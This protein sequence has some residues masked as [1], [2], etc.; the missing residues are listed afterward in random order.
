MKVEVFCTS[1][2]ASHPAAV[3]LVRDVLI[4]KALRRKFANSL[5]RDE[6]MAT[7]LAFSGSPTS[8]STGGTLWWSLS[9]EGR[10]P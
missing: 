10:L 7:D 2:N 4:Q 1:R 8:A 6:A 9:P 5:S 3:K